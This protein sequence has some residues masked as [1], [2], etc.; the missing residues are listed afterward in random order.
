MLGY[1]V[2][3]GQT[4]P[5]KIL[6]IIQVENRHQQRLCHGTFRK[7]ENCVMSKY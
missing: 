2:F 1:I 6:N 3:M 4:P 5:K 7:M